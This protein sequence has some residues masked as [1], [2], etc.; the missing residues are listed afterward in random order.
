MSTSAHIWRLIVTRSDGNYDSW[1]FPARLGKSEICYS[2][3]GRRAT[4]LNIQHMSTSQE[5]WYCFNFCLLCCSR[6]WT[7]FCLTANWILHTKT[8]ALSRQKSKCIKIHSPFENKVC[9]LDMC[10]MKNVN[11]GTIQ[12]INWTQL[13]C[14]LH[15][16]NNVDNVWSNT[17]E[18]EGVSSWRN[19]FLWYEMLFNFHTHALLSSR[20]K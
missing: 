1:G 8:I 14:R 13:L 11:Y 15:G 7:K 20:H 19:L 16:M 12:R 5:A 4:S 3:P 6:A 10:W 17:I 18:N 9:C 2:S